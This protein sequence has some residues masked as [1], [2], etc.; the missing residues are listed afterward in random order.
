MTLLVGIPNLMLENTQAHNQKRNWVCIL[1]SKRMKLM[2]QDLELPTHWACDCKCISFEARDLLLD[3]QIERIKLYH[4]LKSMFWVQEYY[5]DPQGQ[6]Q[7]YSPHFK[8]VSNEWIDNDR[9][10]ARRKTFTFK[11]YTDIVDL[12][13]F[14][15][16]ENLQIELHDIKDYFLQ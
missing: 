8:L 7:P 3:K 1:C 9:L 6:Q 4:N 10:T 5:T 16:E 15:L 2:P 12:L 13:K 11:K 14:I